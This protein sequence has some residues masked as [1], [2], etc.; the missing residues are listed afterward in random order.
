MRARRT[1]RGASASSRMLL[2]PYSASDGTRIRA[3]R[4]GVRE[5]S[6]DDHACK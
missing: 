5:I 6:R 1:E 2:E 3:T 4:D